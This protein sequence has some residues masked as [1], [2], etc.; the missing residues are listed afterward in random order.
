[1]NPVAVTVIVGGD[2]L[3]NQCSS[4]IARDRELVMQVMTNMRSKPAKSMI[5]SS[6]EI[7]L[8]SKKK[9]PT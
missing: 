1:L 5:I 6:C 7:L 9:L 4:W 8:F 2:G 3:E